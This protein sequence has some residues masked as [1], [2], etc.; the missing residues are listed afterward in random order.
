M[1]V[2]GYHR[3][4][5][6]HLG[7]GL[8]LVLAASWVGA[9]AEAQESSDVVFLV[10]EEVRAEWTAALAVELASSG[11]RV[12][13]LEPPTGVTPLLR[14]AQAQQAALEHEAAFAV[15]V[16]EDDSGW[17]LRV[18]ESDAAE[19]RATPVPRGADPRTVA[20]ILVSLLDDPADVP[21]AVTP[22]SAPPPPP[23]SPPATDN[24]WEEP[25]EPAEVPP[26]HDEAEEGAGVEWSGRIGTGGFGLF[27]DRRFIG[28]AML[29]G[30]VGL[31]VSRIEAALLGEM[32]VMLDTLPNL[33]SELQP[34]GRACL[35][36]GPAFSFA[37]TL[38]FHFGVRGCAGF[39]QLR[40]IDFVDPFLGFAD[41]SNQVGA[42]GSGGGYLA[43]SFGLS[44][45]SRL[46][47]RT[48]L[49]GAYF[50]SSMHRGEVVA[51]LSIIMSFF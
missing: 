48:D 2:T 19:A 14:D 34:L 45:S 16:E 20:L 26:R 10:P 4:I 21:L 22:L 31:R 7:L 44:S 13:P 3:Q 50:E 25:T 9:P 29:R 27:N 46:Y 32:G 30:G 18:I 17:S 36:V 5:A 39:A 35:E 6:P 47:V 33:G 41:T 24:R 40:V 23:P 11:A 28:G 15:R 12:V 37:N 42:M 1:S 43:L 8:G 49:E 51:M 38:A